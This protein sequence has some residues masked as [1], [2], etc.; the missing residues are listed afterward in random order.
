VEVQSVKVKSVKRVKKMVISTCPLS[1]PFLSCLLTLTLVQLDMERE[2][3]NLCRFRAQTTGCGNIKFP[4][5]I[6]PYVTKE[7]L[8]E[9]FEVGKRYDTLVSL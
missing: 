1:L 5:P 6:Y 3:K 9:S 2:A 7:V 8:V 4:T